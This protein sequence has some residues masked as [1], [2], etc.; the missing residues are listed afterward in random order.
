MWSLGL[1]YGDRQ[2]RFARVRRIIE[3]FAFAVA[4]R[5]VEIET[6]LDLVRQT[7]E[8]G[9][10]VNIRAQLQIELARIGESIRDVDF[11]GRPV[12]RRATRIGNG[13][14]R[15][16]GANATIEHRNGVSFFLFCRILLCGTI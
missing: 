8:S 11:D 7:G 9:L 5:G 6:V 14:I 3:G 13:D 2:L 12:Y 16:A 10:A 15:G 4:L 1:S